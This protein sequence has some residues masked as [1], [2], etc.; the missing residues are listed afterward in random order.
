MNLTGLIKVALGVA[1]IHESRRMDSG[2]FDIPQSEVNDLVNILNSARA[3]VRVPA[4]RMR[5]V[6]WNYEMASDL[7]QAVQTIDP[8]WWFDKNQSV[9]R[10]NAEVL[11]RYE[12]FKSKYPGWDFLIHDGCQSSPVGVRRIFMYRAI[13]QK[14]YFNYNNCNAT[15]FTPHAGYINSYLSCVTHPYP[16]VSNKPYSWVWQ[17]MPKLLLENT[18]EIACMLVGQS[19]PNA[20]GGYRPNH[21]F[22]Y[23]NNA[24]PQ[25][26]E[27]PYKAGKSMSECPKGTRGVKRLCV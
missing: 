4:V 9:A 7:Q 21:F 25:I 6:G 11:M 24:T 20:A 8:S 12:P 27:Q 5:K 10:F 17:Y 16:M 23:R 15:G 19:G 1:A 13:H 14:P 18:T 26:N 3:H 2:Y 22:C